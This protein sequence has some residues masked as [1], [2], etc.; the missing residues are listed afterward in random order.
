MNDRRT[1]NG[2]NA[3]LVTASASLGAR[4]GAL[5]VT[6]ALFVAFCVLTPFTRV[7]MPRLEALIPI[8]DATFALM[9]LGTASLLLVA[10][11][12]SRIHAV[13]CLASGYLFTSLITVAHTLSFPGMLSSS[14]LLGADPQ[15]SVWLETVPARGLATARYLLC[16][17]QAVRSRERA[18]RYRC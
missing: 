17:A 13:L 12:R 18:I 7:P 6:I 14:S 4:P 15:T 8:F 16:A 5:V 2:S 3:F 9:N 1:S 11:R 10:F